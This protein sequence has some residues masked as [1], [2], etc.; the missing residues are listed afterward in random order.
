MLITKQA[1]C[2]AKILSS[3]FIDYYYLA[4]TNLAEGM[5]TEQ[6][7]TYQRYST[8]YDGSRAVDGDR[9]GAFL[10]V[11]LFQNKEQPS[12]VLRANT[13]S[14]IKELFLRFQKLVSGELHTLYCG[15]FP[16]LGIEP[17][18]LESGT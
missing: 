13:K 17:G 8:V 7:S 2:S 9:N 6:V 5:P 15:R 10:Y 3:F 18:S 16:T 12:K 14:H 1:T 4:R 11:Y